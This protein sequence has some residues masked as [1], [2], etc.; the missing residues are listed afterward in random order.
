[1]V[2][3]YVSSGSRNLSDES[4]AEGC[5]F[6]FLVL[7]PLWWMTGTLL[8]LA[9]IGTAY[10][11]FRRIPRD[12]AVLAI[13]FLWC[14][15]GAS[16]MLSALV[17]S[18]QLNEGVAA[19]PGRMVGM[20]SLG[21]IVLGMAVGVGAEYRLHSSR[22]VR[23]TCIY[24][25]IILCFSILS[26]AY[27]SLTSADELSVISPI[28][29]I[30]PSSMPSVMQ[31]FTMRFFLSDDDGFGVRRL[32]LFFPWSTG[33]SMAGMT[34]MV[35]AWSERAFFWRWAG[36]LGGS[37]ALVGSMSRAAVLAMAASMAIVF[38]VRLSRVTQMVIILITLLA[39]ITAI[40][41]GFEPMET[42]SRMLAEVNGIREGSTDAR[43]M[44]YDKSWE[45][46]QS[47]PIF[48]T[49]WLGE[50]YSEYIPVPIGSH[51]S[52]YGLLYTGGVVG[53][54]MFALAFLVTLIVLISRLPATS[55]ATGLWVGLGMISYGESL[56]S[57]VPSCLIMF[58]FF[59][60]SLARR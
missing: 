52:F 36:F 15:V 59:G 6:W 29:L 8:P 17:N 11:F 40:F 50:D 34:V 56:Y 26:F 30:L 3:A 10:F 43:N 45:G 38:W 18:I 41:S 2:D 39:G 21:W 54:G 16:Q 57:L 31:H 53:F 5:Y 42:T 20:P 23:A 7:T 24:G 51:S 14:L 48:G 13:A 46:F 49:G 22:T 35:V 12:P 44:I 60:A 25:G 58:I 37:T 47:S 1:M 55:G 28:G 19:L 32:I 33:L 4:F 27:G 9:I